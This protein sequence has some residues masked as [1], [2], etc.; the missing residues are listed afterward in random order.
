MAAGLSL[1]AIG[2]DTGGSI[3]LPSSFCGLVG[4]RVTPGR[5]SRDGMSSLVVTQDTPGP[6]CKTVEDA[7]RILDVLVGFDEA[8]D[9][10]SINAFT[11]RTA[12]P[13]QFQDAIKQPF[14]EGKR[15]GV[16]RQA[17]GSHKGITSLLE[18]TLR[19][20]Q[21]A[22]VELIDVEIPD[23]ESLKEQTSVYILRSKQDINDFLA[24]RDGL[25]HLTIED[26]HA[27]GTYHKAL[28]L[29]NAL[30]KG[31]SDPT[32][33]LHFSVAL[34]AIAKFQRTV[35]SIFAKHNLDAIVYPTCQLLA[36]KTKD[37]L[38]GRWSCLDYP[39]N[40]V[41]GSQL[42]WTAVSVPIGT[43]RDDEYPEDP[44]LPIGL[45]ILGVPLSEERILNLAAGIES[46]RRK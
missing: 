3:R 40:T 4:V 12:S 27:E 36:P 45:E 18:N 31:P 11:G 13:T 5:I 37:L 15:L 9:F 20:L 44:E 6:M 23:L 2:G 43:A 1:A 32:K 38:D 25:K 33:S 8:D 10:T 46:L 19:D 24:S 26:L 17:F 16:L 29:I 30:V 22:G 34:L 14:L 28:D 21:S 35:A 39:T 7:A 41:I 42:L